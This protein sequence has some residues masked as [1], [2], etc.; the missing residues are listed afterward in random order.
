[1]GPREWRLPRAPTTAR[2]VGPHDRRVELDDM[3]HRFNLPNR[4]PN[5]IARMIQSFSAGV[6]LCHAAYSSRASSSPRS[7]R[8]R[9][10]P[11]A[12]YL[13]PSSGLP[14]SSSH[15]SQAVLKAAEMKVSSRRTVSP[16]S[17]FAGTH[18]NSLRSRLSVA[19]QACA[20]SANGCGPSL[21]PSRASSASLPWHTDPA[22]HQESCAPGPTG[23]RSHRKS[24]LALS[25]SPNPLPHASFRTFQS[26]RGSPSRESEPDISGNLR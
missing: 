6:L 9:C 5:S 23:R 20:S 3:S 7:H 18:P 19:S 26:G 1:M 15:S 25:S 17:T 12:G 16:H 14:T 11:F 10:C 8:S 22:D 21:I 24:S 13:T 4:I 2:L